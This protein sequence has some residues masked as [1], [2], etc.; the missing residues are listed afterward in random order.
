M[1]RSL[2]KYLGESRARRRR[3]RR[4]NRQRRSSS[5]ENNRPKQSRYE[6]ESSDDTSMDDEVGL[7]TEQCNVQ[8][9]MEIDK[10][11]SVHDNIIH[12]STVIDDPFGMTDMHR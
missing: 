9:P 5:D 12:W 11:N 8:T 10:A 4:H 2:C 7:S 3:K 6:Y 1:I